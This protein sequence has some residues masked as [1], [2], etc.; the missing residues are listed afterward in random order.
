MKL[1]DAFFGDDS[2][3]PLELADEMRVLELDPEARALADEIAST[4]LSDDS[5]TQQLRTL[6]G[7]TMGLKP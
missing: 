3:L 7:Q 4:P 6:V 5:R 1:S 2:E